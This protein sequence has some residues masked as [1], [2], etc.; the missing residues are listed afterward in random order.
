MKLLQLDGTT[1]G[2]Q[3][4]R[5]ALSLAMVTGQ[6]FRMT[7]IRS[8]RPKPGLM[9]QHLTCV[10]AA[11]EISNGTADG[12]EIGST[13]LVFRA[14]KPCC[15]NYQFAIGTAGSTSLLF[16]TLL[17]ALLHA[18]GPSTL[19]LEGGTHNPMAPPFEFL[20]RVF[21]PA[22][23]RMGADV[24][25]SLVQ[26]GFAPVGGGVIECEIQPCE[27]L[28]SI[29]LHERGDLKCMKL[30]VPIRNL[31][32]SIG[33]RM[34]DAALK[35]LPCEDATVEIRES[36]PGRGV[37]CLYEA[38]FEHCEELSSSFGETNVTAE[39][40]GIRAAKSLQDFI[41]SGVPV[42]R[43]LADQLLLPMA[44]AGSGSFTTMMPDDH[45]PTNIAVIEKFLPAKFQIEQADRGK[46][47]L[48]LDPSPQR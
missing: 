10:K 20:D 16:Q 21:L 47:V 15:G 4:L 35:Q 27:K 14:S 42:G 39:R 36:G 23:R 7:N 29:E 1:G 8:K 31:P 3:M 45:L 26:S 19:R 11:C 43:H 25:I 46:R 13:E 33:G 48:T 44:L 5:T 18:D 2:G 38:V 34:L 17:P 30:R 9:R 6:P 22:L 12:A 41:G 37:C 40:V 28:T 24:T 32:I